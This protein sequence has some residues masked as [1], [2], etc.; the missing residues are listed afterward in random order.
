MDGETAVYLGRI[1]DKKH[2]RAYVYSSIGDT[3]LVESWDDFESLM[4][5]GLW[6]ASPYEGKPQDLH[7][8]KDFV[9]PKANKVQRDL[10]KKTSKDLAFE[11][12]D[13]F[14]P[15]G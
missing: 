12:K 9:I 1:V 5:T 6:F 4:K 14:L 2:F 8:D 7:E 3:R 11:V 13:D 10:P 15:R